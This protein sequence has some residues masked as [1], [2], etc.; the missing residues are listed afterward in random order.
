MG[1]DPNAGVLVDQSAFRRSCNKLKFSP[2]QAPVIS[3]CDWLKCTVWAAD[4][5]DGVR[6]IEYAAC[7]IQDQQIWK[8]NYLL[9]LPLFLWQGEIV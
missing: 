8:M 9:S 2:I 1:H 6:L 7:G 5:S 3:W 4:V